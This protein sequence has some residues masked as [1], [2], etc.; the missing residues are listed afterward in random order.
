MTPRLLFPLALLALASPAFAQTSKSR[1]KAAPPTPVP[2]AT[3]L[4]VQ[5]RAATPAPSGEKPLTEADLMKTLDNFKVGDP[6]KARPLSAEDTPAALPS[7]PTLSADPVSGKATPTAKKP[8]AAG[9]PKEG[10]ETEITAKEAA[11]DQKTHQAIFMKDVVVINPEFEV[12]SDKLTVFM[13]HDVAAPAAAGAAPAEGAPAATPAASPQPTKTG[14]PAAAAKSTKKAG[15][16][17]DAPAPRKSSG[18]LERAIAEGSVVITQD[19]VDAEGNVTH[20]VGH[21]RK[22]VYEADTGDITLTGRPDVSQGINTLEAT[23]DWT[24]ITL[25]RDGRMHANGPH[26]STIRDTGSDPA[27]APKSTRGNTTSTSNAR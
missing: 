24:I 26:K 20:S 9:E 3:P 12:R 4:P 6:I 1:G 16:P 10:G 18:G 25:N 2:T 19:K 8:K 23:E 11:F 15:T 21:A 7:L 5:P 13:H 27:T 14:G 17:P 22:A